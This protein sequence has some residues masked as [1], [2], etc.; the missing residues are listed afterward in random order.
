MKEKNPS[1]NRDFEQFTHQTGHLSPFSRGLERAEEKEC[2]EP[3]EGLS[4]LILLSALGGQA[5]LLGVW[6]FSRV[7]ALAVAV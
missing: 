6:I 3:L 2:G 1:K 5:E 4:L 7:G